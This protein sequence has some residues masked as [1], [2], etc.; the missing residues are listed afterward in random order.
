MKCEKCQIETFLPF[1]CPYCG[2]H[3]FSEHRLPENHECPQ[4]EIARL[5][6]EDRQPVTVQGRKSYDYTV[7][8]GQLGKTRNGI[9]FSKKE[10]GHLMVATL[11]VIGVG[12][13]YIGL[14]DL[15]SRSHV[16]YAMLIAFVVIFTASFL[17]HEMAHK[18]VAQREGY[19]AEFRL[20]LIG[21]TLTLLSVVST[22]FKIIAPGAVVISGAADRRR[23]GKISIVGPTT[24][25]ALSIIFLGAAL[26][27]PSYRGLFLTGAAFN[28]SIALFNLIP[29]GIFDGL[30]VFMWNKKIWAFAFALSLVP[31]VLSYVLA[32]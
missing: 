2:D 32:S 18:L 27:I 4:M 15:L 30:K 12:L 1:T 9:L 17:T 7:S 23:I 3:Y 26:L 29:Y 6:K 24:N 22:V 25:V 13:S 11:L 20:T 31:T 28:S 8:Y 19:W 10:V 14:P 21:A 16:D 5:P